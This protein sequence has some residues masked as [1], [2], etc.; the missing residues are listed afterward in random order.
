MSYSHVKV[1]GIQIKSVNDLYFQK[2]DIKDV[3]THCYIWSFPSLNL[4][5][6]FKES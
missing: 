2:C 6:C 1:P 4:A 5:S 3:R